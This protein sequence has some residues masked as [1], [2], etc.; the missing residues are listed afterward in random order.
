MCRVKCAPPKDAKIHLNSPN[1]RPNPEPLHTLNPQN[2]MLERVFR[3]K[4]CLFSFIDVPQAAR[5]EEDVPQGK[6]FSFL[7]F[8]A[9]EG[10]SIL[11]R[12]PWHKYSSVVSARQPEPFSSLIAQTEVYSKQCYM[13]RRSTAS[14]P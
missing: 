13:H 14:A 3:S 5:E 2:L 9:C 4:S 12:Y 10:I 11:C 6:S 1:A 8:C 7:Q